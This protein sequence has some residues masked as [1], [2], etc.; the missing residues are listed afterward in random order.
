[1][2]LE[3]SEP[4]E[5]SELGFLRFKGCMGFG[6]LKI[7]VLDFGMSTKHTQI[8][9]PTQCIAAQGVQLISHIQ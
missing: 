3:M 7:V 6:I 5:L 4:G 8:I 1:M 9:A 2:I